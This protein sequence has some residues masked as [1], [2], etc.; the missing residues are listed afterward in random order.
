MRLSLVWRDYIERSEL[1]STGRA[2]QNHNGDNWGN[3]EKIVVPRPA[4]GFVICLMK[5]AFSFTLY[6]L[7]V[8][9]TFANFNEF[10]NGH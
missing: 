4:C 10:Y 7:Y 6:V 2:T 1:S 5:C 9:K 8:R 3:F